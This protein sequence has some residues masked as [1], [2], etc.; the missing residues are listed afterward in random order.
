MS[1]FTAGSEL[2]ADMLNALEKPVARFRRET[3]LTGID[4]SPEVEWGAVTLAAPRP[5]S[6]Y[7]VRAGLKWGGG[8]AGSIWIARIRETSLAGTDVSG[9]VIE[10][11]GGSP[12]WAHWSYPFSTGASPSAVTYVASLI[13]NSGSST[14]SAQINSFLRIHLVGTTSEMV[15]E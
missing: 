13:R 3:D 2:T 8:S 12:Y 5:N 6:E 1:T 15:T 9:D 10:S 4:D 7:E 11:L 14:A